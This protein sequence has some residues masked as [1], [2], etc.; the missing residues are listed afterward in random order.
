MGKLNDICDA[1]ELA[2]KDVSNPQLYGYSEQVEAPHGPS[3]E[4]LLMDRHRDTAAGDQ[5]ATIGVELSVALDDNGWAYA[6]RKLRDFLDATGT[7]SIEAAVSA[8]ADIASEVE[9]VGPGTIAAPQRIKFP[10]GSR[11]VQRID[12]EVAYD[13]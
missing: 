11:A 9:W 3:A 2:L 7:A 4:V 8:S 12:F 6:W 1:F 5:R 10:D 13:V